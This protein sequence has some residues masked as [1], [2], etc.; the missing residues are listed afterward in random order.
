MQLT[1]T[2]VQNYDKKKDGSQILD[3]KGRPKYRS[4]IKTTEKGD[5]FLTG[6]VYKPLNVGDII[7]AKVTEDVYNGNT[8]LRFDVIPDFKQQG[9]GAQSNSDVLAELRTHTVLLRDIGKTLEGMG[10]ALSTHQTIES[11]KS[12]QARPSTAS[13][14]TPDQEWTA[15]LVESAEDAMTVGGEDDYGNGG[16]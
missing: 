3:N 4:V 8:Q 11:L 9:Q 6:F 5:Q 13:P 12:N 16:F 1:I 2:Q 14:L 15:E 10:M 7:E